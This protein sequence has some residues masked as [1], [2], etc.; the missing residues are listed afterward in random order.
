MPKNCQCSSQG[1]DLD[2]WGQDRK[3]GLDAISW[4]QRLHH[5]L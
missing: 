4:S 3:N 1:Q 5:W 2:R